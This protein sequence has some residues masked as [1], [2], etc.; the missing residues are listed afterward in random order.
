MS[1]SGDGRDGGPAPVLRLTSLVG[2]RSIGIAE[3]LREASSAGFERVEIDEAV[4][5]R[6]CVGESAKLSELRDRLRESGL[7]ASA[8]SVAWSASF[9]ADPIDLCRRA[10]QLGCHCIVVAVD[11]G[12]GTSANGEL[13][14]RIDAVGYRLAGRSTALVVRSETP[15][16]DARRTLLAAVLRE[17]SQPAVGLELDAADA[18]LLERWRHR[19]HRVAVD[20]RMPSE[21]QEQRRPSAARPSEPGAPASRAPGWL[22][23]ITAWAESPL[24]LV[25]SHQQGAHEAGESLLRALAVWRRETGVEWG[26]AAVQRG[27]R[28]SSSQWTGNALSTPPP[29]HV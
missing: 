21:L 16:R 10:E 23:T 7:R 17:L 13:G 27:S 2:R 9:E 29:E 4:L 5:A 26:S 15:D 12:A 19:L 28:L 11:A 25:V 22:A 6:A 20:D 18:E 1:T 8:V 14:R 3:A 24:E